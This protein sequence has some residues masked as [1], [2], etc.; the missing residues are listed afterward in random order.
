MVTSGKAA[1]VSGGQQITRL[2]GVGEN[3][4]GG[5]G[6]DAVFVDEGRP[7]SRVLDP[8]DGHGLVGG[9]V[10][11]VAYVQRGA[12]QTQGAGEPERGGGEVGGQ[13][14]PGAVGVDQ[15]PGHDRCLAVVAEADAVDGALVA[16]VGDGCCQPP[17]YQAS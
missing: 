2:F 5:G 13:P 1:L 3:G 9:V 17:P 10:H 16:R 15:R 11:V 12:V 4:A 14:D 8:H 7:E 6:D